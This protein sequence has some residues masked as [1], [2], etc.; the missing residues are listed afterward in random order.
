MK[1]NFEQSSVVNANEHSPSKDDE[2]HTHSTTA[3]GNSSTASKN[4][5]RVQWCFTSEDYTKESYEALKDWIKNFAK[6]AIVQKVKSSP[7]SSSSSSSSEHKKTYLQGYFNLKKRD[8]IQTI[9]NK[10]KFVGI[11][12]KVAQP[13]GTA[14]DYHVLYKIKNKDKH[15]IWE[16]GSLKQAMLGNNHIHKKT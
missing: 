6:Y 14:L 8:R 7:T 4:L 9:Q 5:T 3:Q 15:S 12:L 1:R 10:L 11:D 16:H 2:N 13:N